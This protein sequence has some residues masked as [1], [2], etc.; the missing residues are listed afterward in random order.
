[1]KIVSDDGESEGTE[2]GALFP[3]GFR[4]LQRSYNSRS[5]S[6]Q[7][8]IPGIL[9]EMFQK[10]DEF[11]ICAGSCTDQ[12]LLPGALIRKEPFGAGEPQKEAAEPLRERASDKQQ[13][14]AAQMRQ[15]PLRAV[16]GLQGIAEFQII[17]IMDGING[18]MIRPAKQI[19][20]GG[21]ESLRVCRALAADTLAPR[22]SSSECR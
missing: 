2:A 22:R 7:R 9:A 10:R 16:A 3:S 20:D 11:G 15:Q 21:I 17:L 5:R 18:R 14:A 6:H 13:V 4:R 19:D 8:I 1:M 12:E